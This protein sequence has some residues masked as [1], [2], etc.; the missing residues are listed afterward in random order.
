[1]SDIA[2]GYE[3]PD[4]EMVILT[5]EDFEHLPLPSTQ[6]V[7]VLE[8]VPADQIEPSYVGRTYYLQAD[9]AGTKP[10]VLLRDAL[11]RT[12]QVAL[13]KVALRNRET[14]AMLRATDDVLLLQAM[15][16][17][18]E[19]RDSE[20]AAPEDDVEIRDQE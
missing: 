12:G 13:V 3:M 17:P 1:Y 11:T 16:G 19:V 8:L 4:G 6:V 18:D 9:N 5:A 10:Y 15:M 7:D 20:F 2:K 14:L